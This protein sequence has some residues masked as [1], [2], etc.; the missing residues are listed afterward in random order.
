[1]ERF[2]AR[3]LTRLRDAVAHH[4]V[5]LGDVRKQRD[6]L[7]RTA[8]GSL[9]PHSRDQDRGLQDLLNMMR[10]AAEAMTLSMAANQ[11]RF[12][13]VPKNINQRPFAEH[14]ERALNAYARQMHLEEILQECVRN[15]F[16]GL[17][18]AKVFMSDSVAVEIEADEWM[19][20][21]RPFVQSISPHHFVY[22]TNATDFRFCSF[23]AD[24]Y[25]VR[26]EDVV[27]DK[28]FSAEARQEMRQQG[29]QSVHE[30]EQEEWGSS[31]D[32]ASHGDSQFEDYL[33][34]TDVF[35]P[36]D[37]L[38]LTFVCDG[39]FKFRT[40]KPIYTQ[41][42]EGEEAGP[43]HFL[44]LGPVPDK[45]TPSSPAQNLLLLHDLVN[46]VYRKLKDQAERQKQV[47][48]G[49][50]GQEDDLRK[51]LDAADGSGLTVA[52]P[53][54]IKQVRYDGPDQNNFGFVLNALGLFSKQ[55][56]NL[57]AKLGLGAQ[58]GTARQEAMVGNNVSRVEAHYQ[59]QFVKFVRRIAKSLSRLLFEDNVTQ[60]DMSLR[61]PGTD[62]EVD[63]HWLGGIQDGAR[64]GDITDYEVSIDPYSMRY[65]DPSQ[66]L[67]ELDATVDRMM[68]AMPLLQQQGVQLNLQ[69]Y[70]K[71]R[72][73]YSDLPEIEELFE[74]NQNPPEQQ[75]QGGSHERTLPGSS[76]RQYQYSGV[77]QADATQDPQQ[78]MA[79]MAPPGGAN[80]G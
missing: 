34:L 5:Q 39:A 17:G 77:S 31:L 12:L 41:T 43:Y 18:I 25:R 67:A 40:E 47:W 46:S 65:R 69:H 78:Q 35:L 75:Q 6:R 64:E 15:A 76:N 10:Q 36:K 11:P 80:L 27:H 71:M 9:Y 50:A 33:Y 3:K 63:D 19:D 56:G 54:S 68:P 79:M 74:F 4:Y 58:T 20:P 59:N 21:G 60:I 73:K 51:I 38:I 61:V 2:G 8:A 7:L 28:R 44:N 23:M 22:D 49:D 70:L 24:R 37:S 48:L 29:P 72:A 42:W 30:V 16:F 1:M 53:E 62:Y 26:Y 45:I 66:R 14:F 55:A 32:G 57:E 13:A 52:Q